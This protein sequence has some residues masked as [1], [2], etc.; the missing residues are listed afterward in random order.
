[1]KSVVSYSKAWVKQ[2]ARMTST[3]NQ[4]VFRAT[5]EGRICVDVLRAVLV[6][7]NLS[8]FSLAECAQ[9]RL[10]FGAQDGESLPVHRSMNREIGV[11]IAAACVRRDSETNCNT[12]QL[13]QAKALSQRKL[14][15]IN[16]V[17]AEGRP[18]GCCF[19][20]HV[21]PATGL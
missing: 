13:A 18:A 11:A 21:V 9:V 19:I 6:A 8:T 10:A 1:M 20:R 4:E 16:R 14:D 2:Q 5:V 17:W 12:N 3:S 7:H 15:P